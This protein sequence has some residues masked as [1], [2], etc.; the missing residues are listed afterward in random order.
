VAAL[1]LRLKLS[2][3][4]KIASGCNIAKELIEELTG[5]LGKTVQN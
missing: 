2:D 4:T 3:I 1:F 5:T